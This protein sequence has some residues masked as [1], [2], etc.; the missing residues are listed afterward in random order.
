MN[1][2]R[3][4]RWGR[5][6]ETPGEDPYLTGTYAAV[7]VRGLQASNRRGGGLRVSACCKHF[8]AYSLE[9]WGG[10][11]R[12]EFDAVVNT[13]DLA[14]TY[15]P[16]FRSCVVR[17]GASCIMCAYNEVNG[18]PM[19]AN[20]P[21]LTGLA[22]DKWAFDGYITSDCDAVENVLDPHNYT[23][24]MPETIGAVMGAG[25]DIDCGSSMGYDHMEEALAQGYI[26]DEQVDNALERLLRV[27]FRLGM[28]DPANRQPDRQ[29]G[30]DAID[31]AA[32]R[33]LALE[34]ARQSVVLLKNDGT[35][36][37]KRGASLALVGPHANATDAM[38]SNYFG[39]APFLISP[40]EG[41]QRRAGARGESQAARLLP[42]NS[43]RITFFPPRAFV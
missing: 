40:L 26:T 41:V 19:C 3:D 6:Q 34:A 37:L 30:P 16:A 23:R 14:D 35:L 25:M 36:P 33:Q 15:L 4:P 24:S 10:V 18:V 32:H 13:Q 11:S 27:Q 7:Y 17:G 9:F 31:T 28:F 5:G 39:I 21:F 38:Q 43:E 2:F 42:L 8:D 29:V 1:I 20:K 12:Y 22:R